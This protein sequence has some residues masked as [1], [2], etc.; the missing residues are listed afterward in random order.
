MEQITT[1]KVE[2]E[3]K[4]N[5]MIQFRLK[6]AVESGKLKICAPSTEFVNKANNAANLV[7]DSYFLSEADIQVLALALEVKA[8]GDMPQILTD[9]YSIQNV[10]KEIGLSFVA[11]ATFGIRR[12]LTWIRYCPACYK[13]YP[14]TYKDSVCSVCGTSLKRKPKAD[15]KTS[16]QICYQRRNSLKKK[17]NQK[18]KKP[19]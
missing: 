14:A 10:A 16:S 7:G 13:T 2:E 4:R 19:L 11:L 8:R 3:V 6:T 5:A 1:P 15:K 18:Q 9:D 17:K 12:V